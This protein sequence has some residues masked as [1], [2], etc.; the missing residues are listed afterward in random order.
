MSAP[1]SIGVQPSEPALTTQSEAAAEYLRIVKPYNAEL[2]LL[3]AK[4]FRW[5]TVKTYCQT[6]ATADREF[7]L[8]LASAAWPSNV[9]PAID[10]FVAQMGETHI[11]Y[12]NVARATTRA[13][14]KTAYGALQDSWDAG[15]AMADTVRVELG[16]SAAPTFS[17]D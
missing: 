1:T 9:Q 2:D 15:G 8:G 3:N 6:L 17:T 5:S 4:E 14:L 12:L 16:L 10:A 11:A 7:S 13:G